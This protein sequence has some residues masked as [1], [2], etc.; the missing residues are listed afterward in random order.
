MKTFYPGATFEIGGGADLESADLNND[1]IADLISF[2]AAL[3]V[4]FGNADGT[5]APPVTV[6]IPDGGFIG[7]ITLSDL[8]G[9]G[10]PDVVFADGSNDRVEVLFGDGLGGFVSD[11]KYDLGVSPS[12][13]V[14]AH[15]N[16]DAHLDII[17]INNSRVR[18]RYCWQ[19]RR[20]VP[21]PD[22]NGYHRSSDG[23][24][25]RPHE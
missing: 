11:A 2:N 8:N 20:H 5:F 6:A 19:W 14:L 21:G 1:G 23:C 13:A 3:Y 12:R 15:V 4:S 7:D 22:D 25:H 16:N 18:W 24:H 10:F 9:D 17:T